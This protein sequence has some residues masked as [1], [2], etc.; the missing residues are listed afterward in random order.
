MRGACFEPEGGGG[1]GEIA[2]AERWRERFDMAAGMCDAEDSVDDPN[3]FA[4]GPEARSD[5]PQRCGV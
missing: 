2:G 3:S 5:I 4:A 1:G